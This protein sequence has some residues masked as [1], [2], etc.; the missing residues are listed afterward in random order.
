MDGLAGHGPSL[1]LDHHHLG[2]CTPGIGR[3]PETD[4]PH[5][6]PLR[7]AQERSK[8]GSTTKLDPWDPDRELACD[9]D[10]PAPRRP[11]REQAMPE[12]TPAWCRH[13]WAGHSTPEMTPHTQRRWGLLREA[14]MWW[15]NGREREIERSGHN[16]ER[17]HLAM[18]SG[19]TTA[20]G[21]VLCCHQEPHLALW[22]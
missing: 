6:G 20:G 18:P 17:H 4:N 1:R 14:S 8:P 9:S 3:D 10:H 19:T 22:F 15:R 12:I 11:G 13:A 16:E 7:Q 2:Q 21:P 5:M